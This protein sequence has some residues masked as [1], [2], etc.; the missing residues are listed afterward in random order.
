MLEMKYDSEWWNDWNQAVPR[1]LLWTQ[2]V[3]IIADYTKSKTTILHLWNKLRVYYPVY[4]M[5]SLHQTARWKHIKNTI[6]DQ[7][8]EDDQELH[9][10]MVVDHHGHLL[11]AISTSTLLVLQAFYQI[12]IEF[13]HNDTTLRTPVRPVKFFHIKL[14]R[15]NISL[16]S[17]LSSRNR[18]GFSQTTKQQS[19]KH[20]SLNSIWDVI[21]CS[22]CL[23]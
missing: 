17:W 13:S 19:W 7:M 15:K 9:P 3:I 2:V 22:S 8:Y 23:S 4:N 6:Y 14:G 20:T 21:L 1:A 11:A 5:H 16:W 10:F 18:K 12:L